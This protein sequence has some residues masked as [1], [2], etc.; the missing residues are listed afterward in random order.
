MN[1]KI[2][3]KNSP[4]SGKY[5]G[6]VKSAKVLAR[7]DNALVNDVDENEL[8][9]IERLIKT[10][11]LVFPAPYLMNALFNQ[12]SKPVIKPETPKVTPAPANVPESKHESI[13][14]VGEGIPEETIVPTG[15]E[16]P[17]EESVNE[18][19]SEEP[20]PT[21][22]TIVPTGSETPAE[23][24]INEEKTKDPIPSEEPVNEEKP[25]EPTPAE[26]KQ[27]KARK[28]SR[29]KTEAAE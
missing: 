27:P 2:F 5:R 24:P 11:S 19:K 3:D 12:S 18:E 21:E 16:T 29:K 9:E 28:G 26:T 23:E 6:C 20:T 15:S 10:A 1:L 22:E 7:I 14:P 25:E 8:N 13:E 4:N 17:A